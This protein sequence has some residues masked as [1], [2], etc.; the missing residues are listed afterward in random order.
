MAVGSIN[1]VYTVGSTDAVCAVLVAYSIVYIN[2]IGTI[3]FMGARNSTEAIHK[4]L[5]ILEIV[6][7]G[8]CR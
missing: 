4:W 6:D 2:S 5:F 3:R 8:I 1:A 7:D